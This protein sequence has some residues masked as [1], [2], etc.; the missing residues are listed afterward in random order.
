MVEEAAMVVVGLLQWQGKDEDGEAQLKTQRNGKKHVGSSF[1]PEAV[2]R[3]HRRLEMR[4]WLS[5]TF[6]WTNRKAGEG[7]CSRQQPIE[8]DAPLPAAAQW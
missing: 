7:W 6:S 4:W 1:S 5:R 2:S 3:R 8:S